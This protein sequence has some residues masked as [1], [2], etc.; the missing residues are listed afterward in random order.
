MR[1]F[2]RTNWAQWLD[3]PPYV[4]FPVTYGITFTFGGI[5]ITPEAEVVGSGLMSGAVFGRAAGASAASYIL[6]K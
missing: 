1:A 2:L 5:K 6:S 3:A 4:C